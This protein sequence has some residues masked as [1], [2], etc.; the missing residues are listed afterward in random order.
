MW[1]EKFKLNRQLVKAVAEA[2]FEVPKEIQLKT[3]TRITGGQDIIGI[4]PEGA[5]KTTTLV[6]ATLNRFNHKADGVPGALIL[7]PDQERVFDIVT[8]FERLNRNTSI[9]IVSLHN[10]TPVD[11]QMDDL[12]DGADI[13]VATPDRARAIYLKLGLNLNKVK[14]LVV[15]DAHLI[16]KQGLQL[17]VVE[18]ANSIDKGQHIVFSEVLHDKLHKMIAPFMV[19]PATVEVDELPEE[20]VATHPQMVYHVPNFGTK[21]N[22]LS[23]F[24]YDEELFTKTVVFANTK[25]TAET[26]YKSLENR[27]RKSVALLSPAFFEHNQVKD[28][29]EFKANDTLRVLIVANE[30]VESI[31]LTE[32][33]FILHFDLPLEKE[34]FITHIINT[35]PTAE[36]ETLAITFA[37]DIELDQVRKIEQA[38]GQKMQSVELPEELVIE[39]TRKQKESEKVV[40]PTRVDPNKHI[41]GEAFHEK[42]PENAKTYNISANKKAKMNK[43]KNH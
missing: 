28:I 1:A 43:K 35:D 12:A 29:S 21:L 7:A 2:G 15:D 42:K 22:L 18:L 8:Q 3:L 27:L 10:G 38:T 26:L 32:I 36:D 31:D 13:V 23:L 14:F 41:P 30:S 9:R 11:Q 33:P 5:G 25:T 17:P 19:N 40:K 6:L 37:T 39:K 16:V 34:V 24:M 4:G 20:T